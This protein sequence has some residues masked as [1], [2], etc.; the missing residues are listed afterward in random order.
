MASSWSNDHTR[1]LQ[2]VEQVPDGLSAPQSEATLVLQAGRPPCINR[3][4]TPELLAD[5]DW[6]DVWR[7]LVTHMHHLPLPQ[8]VTVRAPPQT[9][10]TFFSN[11]TTIA[12][13]PIPVIELYSITLRDVIELHDICRQLPVGHSVLKLIQPRLLD[14]KL[15]PAYQTTKWDFY[16]TKFYLLSAIDEEVRPIL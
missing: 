16:L 9:T 2:F 7:K 11:S 6:K 5:I 10:R 1:V 14:S 13:Q 3:Y 12:T 8:V 4:D 15:P